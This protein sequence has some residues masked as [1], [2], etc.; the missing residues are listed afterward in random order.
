MWAKTKADA[1]QDSNKE[2]VYKYKT[3]ALW[4]VKFASTSMLFVR[5]NRI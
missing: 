3:I 1:G 2:S 5:Y 4:A